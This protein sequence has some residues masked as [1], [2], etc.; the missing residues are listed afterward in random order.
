MQR[1]RRLDGR[2]RG[3]GMARCSVMMGLISAWFWFVCVCFFLCVFRNHHGW[4][5]CR[6]P[7][8]VPA[9]GMEREFHSQRTAE[10]R[11]ALV[12]S[13]FPLGGCCWILGLF[14]FCLFYPFPPRHVFCTRIIL[15]VP[16]RQQRALTRRSCPLSLG[17]FLG[18][19]LCIFVPYI[20]T[21]YHIKHVPARFRNLDGVV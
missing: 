11:R 4:D 20:H 14:S 6:H 13:S 10:G 8:V 7:D 1:L 2:P 9:H 21:P 16:P 3:R 18:W 17:S 5:I 15:D 12:S 19:S